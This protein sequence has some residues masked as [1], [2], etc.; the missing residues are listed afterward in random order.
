MLN[1][2]GEDLVDA[3][4]DFVVEVGRVPLAGVVH[5]F[6]GEVV[7]GVGARDATWTWLVWPWTLCV[8]PA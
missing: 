2:G 8:V 1:A 5:L 4:E 7:T 3:V 6:V